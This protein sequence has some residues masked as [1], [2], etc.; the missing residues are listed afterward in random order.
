VF[1]N[2]TD[3]SFRIS[4]NEIFSVILYNQLGSEVKRVVMMNE[5]DVSDLS[6]GIY[7]ARINNTRGVVSL[8]KIIV[9]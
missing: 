4:N 1:P 6:A 8:R 7:I 2:P 3:K 5:V 9:Y